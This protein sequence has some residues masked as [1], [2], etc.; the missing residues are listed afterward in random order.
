MDNNNLVKALKR[1]LAWYTFESSQEEFDV[2]AIQNI[3][4]LLDKLDP[5]QE[6]E[7]LDVDKQFNKFKEMVAKGKFRREEGIQP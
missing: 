6:I 3:L 7:N 1:K 5:I 2:D 4:L